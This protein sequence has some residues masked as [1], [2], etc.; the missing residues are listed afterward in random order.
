MSAREMALVRR[1]KGN[2]MSI[3]HHVL[4][5]ITNSNSCLY[6]KPSLAISEVSIFIL[7]HTDT[8]SLIFRERLAINNL[9][10]CQEWMGFDCMCSQFDNLRGRNKALAR[11]RNPVAAAR[12]QRT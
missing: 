2:I 9:K 8:R 5:Y 3:L 11:V 6:F 1:R 10:L 4:L 7:L 12:N